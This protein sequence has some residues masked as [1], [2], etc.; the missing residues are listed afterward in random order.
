MGKVWGE[1]KEFINKGSIVEVGV[2]FVLGVAFKTVVDAFA[3]DGKGNPGILGGI[4]GAVLGGTTPN[5]ADR[6]ITVNGSF[7]AVGGLVT[8]AINFLV[9]AA[10]L[11]VIVKAYNRLRNN[12]EET[13]EGPTDV[14]LLAEI[15]DELRD[16][17]RVNASGNGVKVPVDVAA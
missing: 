3:G 15:R 7:I 4:I 11:F 5:F 2:A 16:L 14:E 12:V 8:A 1:F 6:G 10:V 13:P 17:R 9:I